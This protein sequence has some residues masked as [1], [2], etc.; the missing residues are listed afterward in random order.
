MKRSTKQSN[1]FNI[2]TINNTGVGEVN[3]K[4]ALKL[5]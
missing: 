3:V 4:E 1:P 5:W 2:N